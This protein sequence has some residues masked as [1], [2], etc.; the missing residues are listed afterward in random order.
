MRRG[1]LLRIR[2]GLKSWFVGRMIVLM[3]RIMFRLLWVLGEKGELERVGIGGV[4]KGGGK[5]WR[6]RAV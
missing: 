3:L 1:W 5:G 4:G 2:L 6:C